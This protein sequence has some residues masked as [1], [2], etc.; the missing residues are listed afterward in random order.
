MSLCT[1]TTDIRR[2][3][4]THRRIILFMFP[5]LRGDPYIDP[6]ALPSIKFLFALIVFISPNV[7]T[8]PFCFVQDIGTTGVQ[9][10][11]ISL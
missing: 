1:M 10:H 11:C 6:P 7:L 2:L 8:T 4:H 5:Y 3:I 9:N